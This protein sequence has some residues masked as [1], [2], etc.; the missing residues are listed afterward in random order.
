MKLGELGRVVGRE[1]GY[2]VAPAHYANM[3]TEFL[4]ETFTLRWIGRGGWTQWPPRS[5]DLI[6]LDVYFCGICTANHVQ[7]SYSQHSAPETANQGSSC[8]CH[9]DILG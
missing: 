2:A 4:D 1:G 7:C 9:S 3:V 6:Q 5:P 8:I